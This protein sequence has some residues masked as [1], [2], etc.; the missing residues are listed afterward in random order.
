MRTPVGFA[1]WTTDLQPL[2]RGYDGPIK[3]LVGMDTSV[4]LSGVIV[5]EHAVTR[6][7]NRSRAADAGGDQVE[8]LRSPVYRDISLGRNPRTSSVEINA[9]SEI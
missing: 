7:S 6:T 9:T 3:M 1:F 8:V 5:V 4:V 2:E